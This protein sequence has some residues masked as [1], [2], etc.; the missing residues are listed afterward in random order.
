MPDTEHLSVE[1]RI[2]QQA[3]QGD[4]Q[5]FGQLYEMYADRIFR[6]LFFRTGSEMTAEDLMCD[7]F[8]KAWA[9]MPEFVMDKETDNFKAWLYRIAHNTLIDYHRTKKNEISIEQLGEMQSGSEKAEKR[10]EDKQEFLNLLRNLNMLDEISR[11]VLVHR[12]VAGLSHRETAALLGLRETHV[13]VI[14]YR[15]IKKMRE[16]SGDGY[17]GK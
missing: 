15:A 13:R 2:V 3:I 11:E 5:A 1:A 8:F 12:F 9:A 6:Y 14:Q 17:E 4:K 7:A 16:L 10:I